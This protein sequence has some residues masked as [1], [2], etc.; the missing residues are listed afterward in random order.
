M[1]PSKFESRLGKYVN[2]STVCPEF[3][4]GLVFPERP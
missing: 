1:I 3:D 4:I 2:Y